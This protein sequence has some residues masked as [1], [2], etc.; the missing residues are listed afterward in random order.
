MLTKTKCKWQDI[1]YSFIAVLALFG[2]FFI[3]SGYAPF[4]DKSLAI[5]D[6]T[7]Q[8]LDFFAY[9]KDVLAGENSIAY[10]FS[11]T[12][13]G[14]NM[15]VFSYYLTSPFN[16]LIIFFEK[17]ELNSFFNIL[18]V[19]KCAFAAATMHYF[20]KERFKDINFNLQ[21]RVIALI[22]AVSYAF[23]QFTLQQSS[24][25]MWL[26]GVYMLPLML[27][28]VYWTITKKGKSLLIISVFLSVIFNWYMAGINCLFAGLWTIFEVLLLQNKEEFSLSNSVSYIIECA[29]S[30]FSGLLMSMFIFLPTIK[31]LQ[32]G[33]RGALSFAELFDLSFTGNPLSIISSYS[34]GSLSTRTTT[35]LFCGS[36]AIIGFIAYFISKKAGHSQKIIVGGFSL[37]L[38]L[39]YYWT[40]AFTIFSLFKSVTSY[41]CRYSHLGIFSIIFI[42]CLYYLQNG[43]DKGDDLYKAYFVYT[44]LFLIASFVFTDFNENI[45]A[46]LYTEILCFVVA[47]LL[48]IVKTNKRT[49]VAK[50]CVALLLL[51]SFVELSVNNIMIMEQMGYEDA[52]VFAS[53][54]EGAEK[55]ISAIKELDE[56]VYRI[57][58]LSPRNTDE[59]N[60]TSN[61]NEALAYNY[62]SLSGYTSSPDDAQRI[63]LHNL[64]YRMT[65]D[66]F[67]IVNTSILPVD[68][69]LRVK[70][71]ISPFDISGYK[72]LDEIPEYN[73]KSAYLNPYTIPFAIKYDNINEATAAPVNFFE[74]TNF[75]YS[76]LLDEEIE[77]FKPM[78]FVLVNESAKEVVY[79]IS[80]IPYNYALYGAIIWN[81][82]FDAQ[83]TINDSY[84]TRCA[85]G[86]SPSIFH[87][88]AG[89]EG[90]ATIKLEASV[91][92]PIDIKET[93]FYYCDLDEFRQ[94]TTKIN[95][96]AVKNVQISN[97]LIQ[98]ETMAEAGES[99][100]LP[101]AYDEDWEISVNGKPASVKLLNSLYSI[102]LS[103][104]MNVITMEYNYGGKT[105]GFAL[106]LLGLFMAVILIRKRK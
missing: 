38:I 4:G 75:I 71:L 72:K 27:L 91:N 80:D 55:Q 87:V 15:A 70:Y 78:E 53:Y 48:Y 77:I 103:E 23:S 25:I 68:S 39:I 36:L 9:L 86:L 51:F 92:K 106:S 10:T 13:G 52:S 61:Y 60:L 22:L 44:T 26:D 50:I 14:T 3:F 2:I 30:M 76:E 40:P 5:M 74:M 54:T 19:L 62:W 59:M 93:L 88:S 49:S 29:L 31:A 99:L 81:S 58:N 20:I 95:E 98:I 41:Y 33:N 97:G 12:L 66:N 100:F 64:G 8:Y 34:I 43:D 1:I 37:V 96:K 45:K 94:I 57:S 56:G 63:L 6:G 79:S 35:S 7:V 82:F 18:V 11:K 46:I 101:V 16:L 83:M 24:N 84:Q 104:G 89:K 73:G 21:N 105:V 17:A 47:L 85:A 65:G 90:S 32:K 42:A 102:E 28:G 69:L 67:C